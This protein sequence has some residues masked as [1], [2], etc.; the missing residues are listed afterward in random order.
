MERR[1]QLC[2]A[3]VSV[4][5]QHWSSGL[6]HGARVSDVQQWASVKNSGW[7]SG[8]VSGISSNKAYGGATVREAEGLGAVALGEEQ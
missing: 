2:V 4:V 3:V 6:R 1:F 8:P 7:A 5:G